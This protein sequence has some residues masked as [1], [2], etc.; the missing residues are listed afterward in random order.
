MQYRGK[1]PPSGRFFVLPA[2]LSIYPA[3]VVNKLLRLLGLLF[4][5]QDLARFH[6]EVKSC[7]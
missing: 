6:K 7:T 3:K 5:G 2:A 1:A 4:I